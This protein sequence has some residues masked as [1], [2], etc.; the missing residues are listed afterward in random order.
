M[1]EKKKSLNN[2]NYHIYFLNSFNSIKIIPG[3]DI[4]LLNSKLSIFYIIIYIILIYI[5]IKLN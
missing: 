2:T 4:E 1:E 3:K 5:Y